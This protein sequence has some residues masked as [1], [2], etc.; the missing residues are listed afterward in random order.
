VSFIAHDVLL[1]C[2]K[3]LPPVFEQIAAHDAHLLDHLKRAAKNALLNCAE[4][5]RRRGLDR[6]NRFRYSAGEADEA[7]DALEV[8]LAWGYADAGQLAELIALYDRAL[9]LLYPNYR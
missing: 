9:G 5:R 3:K 8:A 4:A 2:V 1:E 6:A 7:K